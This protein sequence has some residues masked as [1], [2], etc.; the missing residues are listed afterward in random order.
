MPEVKPPVLVP[1]RKTSEF[2][3][4]AAVAVLSVLAQVGLIGPSDA[5]PLAQAI[6][7][8]VS[9]IVALVAV[10]SY[11]KERTRLKLGK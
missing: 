6:S 5:Q 2:L 8:T 10:V 7:E 3:L 1:G 4:T 11:V 9:G